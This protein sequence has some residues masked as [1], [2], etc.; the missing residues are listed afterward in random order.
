MKTGAV[1]VPSAVKVLNTCS[2]RTSSR[3]KERRERAEERIE[4]KR[5]E[6]SEVVE[7][8]VEE[9]RERLCAEAGQRPRVGALRTRQRGPWEHSEARRRGRA[10]SPTLQSPKN[11]TKYNRPSLT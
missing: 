8:E 2:A 1:E 7:K 6:E 5:K 10:F 4:A 3:T 11:T 9:R